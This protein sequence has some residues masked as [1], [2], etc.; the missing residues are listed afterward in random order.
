MVKSRDWENS[1]ISFFCNLCR[2]NIWI[3]HI[4]LLVLTSGLNFVSRTTVIRILR[5]V[6]NSYTTIPPSLQPDVPPPYFHRKCTNRPRVN[7]T[8]FWQITSSMPAC[9][10]LTS[11]LHGA[12]PRPSVNICTLPT[13]PQSS[14]RKVPDCFAPLTQNIQ[15]GAFCYVGFALAAIRIW[16]THCGLGKW[17]KGFAASSTV[18]MRSQLHFE[19]SQPEV[20]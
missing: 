8:I 13:L 9:P 1:I 19:F 10:H 4:C 18:C 2:K 16:A 15:S 6:I 17:I 3:I 12:L 14:K 11:Y 7:Y 5:L 20:A